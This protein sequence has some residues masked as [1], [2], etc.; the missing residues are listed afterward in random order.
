MNSEKIS[1]EG[2]KKIVFLALS[3]FFVFGFSNVSYFLPVYYAQIGMKSGDSAG[4]L[5][6][7]FYILSVISRP[8]LANIVENWGF[9]R[10]F[11]AA[12]V[13]S[14]LS[15]AGVLLSGVSFWPGFISRALLGVA[16]S[17]F[18]IGLATYQAI[19]F[20]EEER[21]RAFSLIMAGGLAP[22][23]T[24]VPF[25][26]W[27]LLHQH[28]GLYILM[29][30]LVCLGAAV[31]TPSIPGIES[32]HH[33]RTMKKNG[34]SV[35]A[36][37]SACLRIPHFRLALLSLF[38]FSVADAAAAFMAPMTRHYGLMASLFLSANAVIGVLVRL[39]CGKLLDRIPRNK[40]APAAVLLTSG[41]LFLATI[42]P[43]PK[44]LIALGLIFGVGMGLGFPLHLALISDYVPD[45]LQPQAVSLSWFL[46]GLNF[47]VVS[48]MMGWLGDFFG[49]VPVFRV[50]TG[51]VIVGAILE[52]PALIR[53]SSNRFNG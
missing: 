27:L 6:A 2:R 17:I 28:N 13:L 16:S 18:L 53:I 19:A 21:G 44:S 46:M 40:L 50:I 33:R 41:M 25:A 39:F 29:P 30:L 22:M 42:S 43:T 23:M 4:W 32:V 10:V 48:L 37:L 11:I 31:I 24:I 34:Q 49:P 14:V 36:G 26:D 3:F 5:V 20:K 38:L 35:L 9:R 12:G 45:H 1:A 47:A 8:F 15:S 7:A 52:Y 51:L